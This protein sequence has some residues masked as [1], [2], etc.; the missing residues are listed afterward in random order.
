VLTLRLGLITKS[1]EI[2]WIEQSISISDTENGGKR[3]DG[4]AKNVTERI[5]QQNALVRYSKAIEQS[6]ISI[7]FTDTQGTI[8]YVNPN[9]EKITG[10]YI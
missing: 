5:N 9:F 1:G 2:R 7:I 8:E 3:F 4:I 6:P 10:I